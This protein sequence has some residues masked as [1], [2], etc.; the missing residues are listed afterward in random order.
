MMGEKLILVP[1]T[2]LAELRASLLSLR[3]LSCVP[4][5]KSEFG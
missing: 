4:S 1:T 5:P 3:Q 2:D